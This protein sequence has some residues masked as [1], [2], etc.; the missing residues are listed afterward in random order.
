MTWTCVPSRGP[1]ASK[2][3]AN[4]IQTTIRPTRNKF[5]IGCRWLSWWLLGHV[6]QDQ[7][8]VFVGDGGPNPHVAQNGR[9][10]ARRKFLRS[11]VTAA[12]VSPKALL[13]SDAHAVWIGRVGHCRG[14][15]IILCGR[16]RSGE[17]RRCER[18]RAQQDGQRNPR[19]ESC[20]HGCGPTRP[21]GTRK[22]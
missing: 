10:H 1:A 17:D 18:Q 9:H 19:V 8:P 13:P 2:A 5:V 22:R 7:A 6:K 15:G 3:L 11:V 20:L 21:R 14:G 4:T 12:A 16:R